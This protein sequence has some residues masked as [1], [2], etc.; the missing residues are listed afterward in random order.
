MIGGDLDLDACGAVGIVSGLDPKS[1]SALSVRSGPGRQFE[2]IDKLASGTRIWLCDHQGRWV[3]IVYGP[4]GQDCGVSTSSPRRR[5][6]AG[7]CAAGWVF[8][9]Y[10][11]LVAG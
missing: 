3:G 2:A 9:K 6:Y 5:P 11:A 10:V 4:D 7:P 1:S 8:E